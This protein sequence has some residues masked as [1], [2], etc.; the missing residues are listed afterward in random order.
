MIISCDK[1]N[2]SHVEILNGENALDVWKEKLRG[3]NL[4]RILI[5][6]GWHMLK[7]C[8]CPKCKSG[9]GEEN[10]MECKHQDYHDFNHRCCREV[11]NNGDGLILFDGSIVSEFDVCEH[12]VNKSL[13]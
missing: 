8:L 11:S 10:C 2:E 13:I 1:C 3:L 5:K 9:V 6:E 12:F 7:S 4:R